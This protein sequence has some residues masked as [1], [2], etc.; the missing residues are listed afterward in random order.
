LVRF[1]RVGNRSIYQVEERGLAI[2]RAYV[3]DLWAEALPSLKALAETTYT[4]RQQKD[5]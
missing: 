2:L 3:D 1:H 5:P 4:Q